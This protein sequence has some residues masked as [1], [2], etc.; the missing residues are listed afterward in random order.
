[1]RTEDLRDNWFIRLDQTRRSCGSGTAQLRW[2]G[3]DAAKRSK[4]ENVVA[5]WTYTLTV[6]NTAASRVYTVL[7]PGPG[8]VTWLS[9]ARVGLQTVD[10]LLF[11]K[12][13][14]VPLY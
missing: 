7:Q 12:R 14:P 11:E 8:Q 2:M 3:H 1:M 4:L 9:A 10:G 6:E 13:R 5:G